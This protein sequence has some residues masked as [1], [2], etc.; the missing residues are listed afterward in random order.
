MQF[1]V[2]CSKQVSSFRYTEVEAWS[3]CSIFYWN[4]PR[5][6][7]VIS[8][9]TEIY[10]NCSCVFLF[11]PNQV[12]PIFTTR[13]FLGVFWSFLWIGPFFSAIEFS[14]IDWWDLSTQSNF[15]FHVRVSSS[16]SSVAI[17]ALL[18][19]AIRNACTFSHMIWN[20]DW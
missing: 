19:F 6:V 3:V 10:R 17:I 9:W 13:D 16:V 12:F 11:R 4:M 18:A 20:I 7:L 15:T 5:L 14:N 8:Q 1:S 2:W